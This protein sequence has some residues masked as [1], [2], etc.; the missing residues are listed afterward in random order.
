METLVLLPGLICDATIWAHQQ[1]R[2]ATTREVL[3]PDYGDLASIA[4]MADLV[5]GQAP[6]RFALAGHSMG[7]RVAL[8]I[9]AKAPERVARLALID[10]GVHPVRDGERDKRMALLEL[11]RREGMPA[12]VAQWLPP[13]V[14]PAAASDSVLMAPLFAMAER[15]GLDRFA[16]QIEALLGRRD[17]APLLPA[18]A[19]PTLVGVGELDAWSPP[20]QHEPIV[21]AL[22]CGRMAV[23][24]G[25]G[26]MAPWEAPEAVSAA[27]ADW[28]AWRA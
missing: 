12:L 7:A 21:A 15:Q 23:F 1:A 2:F 16:R 4:D 6:A 22:P 14:A 27:M 3:I 9:A 5:L 24:R 28:L 25:A 20:A 8:E 11:G 26:H 13:M 17:A 18:I 19:C 10:T